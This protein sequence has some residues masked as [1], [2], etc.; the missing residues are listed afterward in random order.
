MGNSH[1]TVDILD[2]KFHNHREAA[3]IKE[4]RETI[5][6]GREM[7]DKLVVPEGRAGRKLKIK[8]QK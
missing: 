7:M 2:I 3:R 1:N 5:E 6:D 8:M 4:K